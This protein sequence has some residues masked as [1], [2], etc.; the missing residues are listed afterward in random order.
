[1]KVCYILPHFYPHVGGGEQAFLDLIEELVKQNVEARVITSTSG[2][3]KGRKNY[4]GIDIYYYDWKMLFGHPMVKKEDLKEHITWADLVHVGVY[5]PVRLACNLARKMKKPTIVTAHEV[6]GK[7]W[8]WVESNKIKALAFKIYETYVV[9]TKCNYFHTASY[10]T[11]RDLEKC[12]KK[13]NI[14]NIYWIVDETKKEIQT[15]KTKFN[16]Y[17]GVTDEDRVFLNYGRPGK[18]K[19]VF[20]YLN[21]IENVVQRLNK[22]ELEH[23]KFCFI[24][25]KDPE[26][27]RAKF[28]KQ[29]KEHQLEKY[30]IV[31][32]SVDRSDLEN[33]IMCA[34]YVVVPSI[35]EGFGLSAIEACN[36]GKKLI[37]SSRRLFARGNFWRS[38]SV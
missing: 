9:K 19:G 6:L 35:T 23:I 32:E 2:G 1:M 11:Q 33:Y 30:V 3:V 17:F 27:E 37:Y 38:N 13:A 25:A 21:A 10:A 24:M 16:Q 22:Q 36:M 12:N 5:S 4:K 18:T 14:R 20:V 34:N 7:R 15:N 26:S 29:V 8:F 31:K 28:V